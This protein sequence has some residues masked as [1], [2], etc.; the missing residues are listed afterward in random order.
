MA[1]SKILEKQYITPTG[2]KLLTSSLLS[3]PLSNGVPT[4]RFA[5]FRKVD[6]FK[7]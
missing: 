2:L 4:A 7:L 5:L 6:V 1:F 3:K